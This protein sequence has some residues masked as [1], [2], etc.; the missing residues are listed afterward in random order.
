MKELCEV[1]IPWEGCQH[2]WDTS[3]IY[4]KSLDATFTFYRYCTKCN[5]VETRSLA[6]FSQLTWINLT[7]QESVV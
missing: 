3:Q 6:E 2:D 7:N 1:S 5:A 4:F